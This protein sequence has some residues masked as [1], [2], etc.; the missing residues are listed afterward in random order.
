MTVTDDY[1]SG[2]DGYLY[3]R[4]SGGGAKWAMI[5]EK[6]YAR[7]KGGY[8]T[9]NGGY[10]EVSLTDLT[11]ARAS[12]YGT[13]ERT[14]ADIDEKIRTGYAVMSS[15]KHAWPAG[16]DVVQDHAY[17]VKDVDMSSSPP[18][19]TMVN[20]WGRNAAAPQYVTLTENQWR[21]SFEDVS[22]VKVGG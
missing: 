10:D 1:P 21:K 15:T 2:R 13:G 6:A 7:F 3:A 8:A 19:I 12:T 5:Y 18:T 11:G 9:I 14:L 4:P 22:Y 20:P 17:Y 16:G